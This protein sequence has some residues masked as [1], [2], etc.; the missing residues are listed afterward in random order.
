LLKTFP[1]SSSVLLGAKGSS[2]PQNFSNFRLKVNGN[3]IPNVFL[4]T[5]KMKIPLSLAAFLFGQL[6]LLGA[7]VRV[8]ECMCVCVSVCVCVCACVCACVFVCVSVCVCICV[9][10][11]VSVCAC[12][13]AILSRVPRQK[14]GVCRCSKS[15]EQPR[16]FKF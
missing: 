4:Q 13:S 11:C 14:V 5:E 12:M 10:L 8:C 9:C 7:C 3:T 1:V 15:E 16:Q 2:F 6:V